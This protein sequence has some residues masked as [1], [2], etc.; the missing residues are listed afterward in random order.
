MIPQG[1]DS[2]PSAHEYLSREGSIWSMMLSWRAADCDIMV[3]VAPVSMI[4]SS[5]IKLLIIMGTVATVV[6]MGL[7][8]RLDWG[9]CTGGGSKGSDPFDVEF[10]SDTYI[11]S[12][13]VAHA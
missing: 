4:P 3:F 5:N 2:F 7:R 9:P 6:L 8:C 1:A 11:I 12:T 13:L 10:S